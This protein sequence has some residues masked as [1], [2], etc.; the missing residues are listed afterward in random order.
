MIHV[1]RSEIGPSSGLKVMALLFVGLMLIFA[2]LFTLVLSQD[3]DFLDAAFEVFSAFGT[4]GLS[5]R[6]C[7]NPESKVYLG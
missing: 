2:A 1:Q 4:V 3:I 5:R 7:T 6:A